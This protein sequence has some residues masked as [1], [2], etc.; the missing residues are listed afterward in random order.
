MHSRLVKCVKCDHLSYD[1][2]F[3]CGKCNCDLDLKTRVEDEECPLK[4][5]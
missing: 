1:V 5:W 4:N 2:A 3:Y